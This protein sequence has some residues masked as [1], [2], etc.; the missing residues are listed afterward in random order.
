MRSIMPKE[1]LNLMRAGSGR[2]SPTLKLVNGYVID[3]FSSNIIKA[4]VMVFKDRVVAI[5]SEEDYPTSQSTKVVDVSGKYLAPG[6]MDAHIHIESTLLIPAQLAKILIP[7]GVTSL[8]ADPHEIGNVL[9]VKGIK[10][11]LKLTEGIPLRV[12]IEVPSRVP[13]APGLET[14]GAVLGVEEVGELLDLPESVS[15][16]ELNYQNL[17][18]GREEYFQKI[19]AAL[20][21]G[22]VANGHLAML[23]GVELNAALAAGLMDDHESVSAEEAMEKVVR[24]A[25]VFVREGTSERNLEDIIKGVLGRVRDF[26]RFMFCTDDKHPED[27]VRE[28]HIDYNVRKAVELG[29]D[30]VVA[31]QMATYNIATHF[32]VDHLV[33]AV[34]PHRKA[35]IVVISNIDKVTI[36]SVIFNG[37]VVYYKGKLLYEPPKAEIPEYA[38]RTININPNLIPEDLV[39]TVKEGVSEAYVRVID[40]VPEQIITHESHEWLSVKNG[41]IA[42][43]PKRDLL[44]IAVVD[45]HRGSKSIG[46]S[47]VRGFGLREGAIA[48]SVAHDHHNVVIVGTNPSDMLAAVKRLREIGGGF[49]AIKGGRLVGE[50]SLPFAGL[51]SL[52]PA[53]RVIE[54]LKELNRAVRESL[55]SKLEAPFMQLEFI[56]LPTVPELG[57]TDKGLID[58]VKYSIISAVI[59]FK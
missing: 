57:L 20:S 18:S 26:R 54:G 10:L 56:T 2:I 22:K 36:D 31:I 35:D 8:F 44:H 59:K 28:G 29:V 40:V 48:S 32:R 37:E 45:R 53:E 34:A 43:D 27:I 4:D 3:V 24:G 5:G 51:L 58:S 42:S 17:L 11:L 1:L 7:H 39:I 6:F 30:P 52:E 19:A 15:L 13:T 49:V 38:L 25:A 47:F 46:K 21:R 23:K 14:S 9:G 16:G 33:G 41:Y 50:L 55:G 12:F